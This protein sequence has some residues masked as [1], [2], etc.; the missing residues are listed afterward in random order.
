MEMAG[1]H[2]SIARGM[3]EL[4]VVDDCLGQ[5]LV[6]MEGYRNRLVHMYAR[7]SDEE[8]YDIIVHHLG[9]IR[10]FVVQIRNFVSHLD[11]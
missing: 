1:E 8:L 11:A 2:K 4:D 3:M 9:D 5:E 6:R 7:V 10:G